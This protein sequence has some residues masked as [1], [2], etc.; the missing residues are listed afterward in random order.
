VT[1]RELLASL[2]IGVPEAFSWVLRN[3]DSVNGR[4]DE[5]LDPGKEYAVRHDYGPVGNAT[6]PD[7]LEETRQ[8]RME[9]RLSADEAKPPRV[10]VAPEQAQV[11][12]HFVRI[13]CVAGLNRRQ[14][15]TRT[16]REIAVLY[17]IDLELPGPNGCLFC[18]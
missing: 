4:P 7:R 6:A 12:M 9:Q 1:P 3:V 14:V 10:V 11:A 15:A 8:V 16:A 17:R 2:H 13:D 5:I 18:A